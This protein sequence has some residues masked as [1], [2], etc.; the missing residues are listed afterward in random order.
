M[1]I[2]S[3]I[4]FIRQHAKSDCGVACLAMIAG[5][6]YEEALLAVGKKKVLK[7]GMDI[8]TLKQAAKRLGATL[9]LHRSVDIEED[10]GILAVRSDKWP[11]D[12]VVI[13]FHGIVLDG[14]DRTIWEADTYLKAHSARILSLLTL[15]SIPK[16]AK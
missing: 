7:G 11:M 4:T 10:C 13:L 9:K 14:D 12:H 2:P 6:S 3:F 15:E 5:V 16:E 1:Y 8:K